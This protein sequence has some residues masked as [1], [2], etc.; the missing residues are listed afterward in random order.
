MHVILMFV[1]L[2][3]PKKQKLSKVKPQSCLS[4]N[5]QIKKSRKVKEKQAMEESP[6]QSYY[7]QKQTSL[8]QPKTAVSFDQLEHRRLEKILQSSPHR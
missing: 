5:E 3:Q 8:R 1:F 4:Q 6:P 2:D 7:H